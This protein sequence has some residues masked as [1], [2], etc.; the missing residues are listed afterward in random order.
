MAEHELDP[1]LI[2]RLPPE[3]ESMTQL[4]DRALVLYLFLHHAIPF[5]SLHL[6][7]F[8][9]LRVWFYISD[10]YSLSLLPLF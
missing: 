7:P 9:S 2:D 1:R 8:L 3:P 10:L 4:N 6:S 5:S